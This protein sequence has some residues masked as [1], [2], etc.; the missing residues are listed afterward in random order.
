[1]SVKST[2]ILS[3]ILSK[4]KKSS[5]KKKNSSK[6]LTQSTTPTASAYEA[7][8][9]DSNTQK[10]DINIEPG[11]LIRQKPA[12]NRTKKARSVGYIEDD[13]QKTTN[14]APLLHHLS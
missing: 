6:R 11:P 5:N 10:T 13:R 9:K 2:N 3:K 8:L 14:L 4:R 1:M 7:K 12:I